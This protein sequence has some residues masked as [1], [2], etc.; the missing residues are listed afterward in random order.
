MQTPQR[1][2]K[3]IAHF[4]PFLAPLFLLMNLSAKSQSNVCPEPSPTNKNLTAQP[5]LGMERK[6]EDGRKRYRKGKATLI[7]QNKTTVIRYRIEAFKEML[8]YFD[9]LPDV[10]SINVYIGLYTKS[11]FGSTGDK[12]SRDHRLTIFFSPQ[13]P[14]KSYGYYWLA[15]KGKSFNKQ[16]NRLTAD[17]AREAERLYIQGDQSP[18]NKL[19]TTIDSNSATTYMRDYRNCRECS[20]YPDNDSVNHKSDTRAMIYYKQHFVDE[21]LAEIGYQDTLASTRK[22]QVEGIRVYFDQHPDKHNRLYLEFAFVK[23]NLLIFKRKFDIDEDQYFCSRPAPAIITS[24][25][26]ANAKNKVAATANGA[27]AA[28]AAK[29]ITVSLDNGQMCP[30]VCS[31]K[32]AN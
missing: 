11:N 17:Q 5:H 32:P 24:D 27:A 19:T 20:I 8:N 7:R 13:T 1:L 28:T 26:S 12:S 30:P 29:L 25:S 2:K 4:L 18:M 16:Q 21:F 9:T 31:E 10:D 23:R 6:F 3:C 22:K 14:Y 15:P